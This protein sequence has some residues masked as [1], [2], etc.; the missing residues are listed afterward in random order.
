[1]LYKE[2]MTKTV[3][4]APQALIDQL[5]RALSHHQAGN[6]P[7][8]ESAYKRAVQEYPDFPDALHMASI[9]YIQIGKNK[10]AIPLLDS[11]LKKRPADFKV[12][13][14]VAK[15]LLNDDFEKAYAAIETAYNLNKTDVETLEIYGDLSFRKALFQQARHLYSEALKARPV[16]KNYNRLGHALLVSNE[17]AELKTLLENACDKNTFDYDT[18]VLLALA[19]GL[20]RLDSYSALINAIHLQPTRDEAKALFSISL[21]YGLPTSEFNPRLVNCVWLCLESDRVNHG[22]LGRL[23]FKQLFENPENSQEKELI[24]CDD[25]KHFVTLYSKAEYR[26]KLLTPYFIDG[27]RKIALGVNALENLLQHMRRYYLETLNDGGKNLTNED[28]DFLSALAVQSFN[29]E[30]VISFSKTEQAA[31]KQLKENLE[32]DPTASLASTLIYACY[33]PLS[34]FQNHKALKKALGADKIF[35][36]VYRQHVEEQD[37]QET[38]KQSLPR[39][40]PVED[41]VSQSV[42]RQYEENPYPRWRNENFIYPAAHDLIDKKY[43]TKGKILIA[44]CGTGRQIV[45]VHK[46]RPYADI[47]A[48]DLSSASLGYAMMKCRDYG[49]K[50]VRFLQGDL[51]DLGKLDGDFDEIECMGVLHHMK[52]P[53]AGLQSLLRKLKK[54]GRI[55]L[56]LYSEAARQGVLKAR[57]VIEQQG[58]PSTPEGI[59]AC[60]DYMISVKSREPD[61]DHLTK[62]PDFFSLSGCR[63]L[64]FHVQETR[65][66]IPQIK[67]LLESNGLS[68]REFIIDDIK[69]T[70]YH[71]KFPGDKNC[72][73]L[74]NFNIFEQEHPLFF[75]GMYKFIAVKI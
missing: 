64:I 12:H 27:V 53:E 9:F 71:K 66:T 5:K 70:L 38:F 3:D 58:F 43:R 37:I 62:S 26:L 13:K 45:L 23:W 15:C 22:N 60:R 52:D 16:A 4:P 21:S 63:D 69:K 17:M 34:S 50:N 11:L 8:A 14:L 55:S 57:S 7:L 48:I 65:Y 2:S 35:A 44:G 40:S 47:T 36:E 41:D 54:G 61:L 6:F 73:D 59:R 19:C 74:D 42:Q 67:S 30:F 39:L 28:L 56:G 29:N 49:I 51:L 10:L 24:E 72:Q 75:G 68:F 1:M 20:G 18:L 33:E 32:S 25:Y 46:Y 31:I